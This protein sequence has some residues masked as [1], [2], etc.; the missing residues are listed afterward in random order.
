MRVRLRMINDNPMIE[1]GHMRGNIGNESGNPCKVSVVDVLRLIRE[2]MIVDVTARA[3][4]RD[5]N[6]VSRI[7]VVIAAAVVLLR[8]S[9]CIERVVELQSVSIVEIHFLEKVT[10][11][12]RQAPRTD[13]LEITRIS[14]GEIAR[15]T[16][17]DHVDVQLRND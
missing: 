5:R 17:S 4:E 7:L 2:L 10:E 8:V 13:E 12:G 3:H 1:I 16:S 9:R 6:S 11:L 14:A 15:L